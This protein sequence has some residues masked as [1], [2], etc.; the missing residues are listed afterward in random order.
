[1][2]CTL[3]SDSESALERKRGR[4]REKEIDREKTYSIASPSTTWKVGRTAPI[5]PKARP[6]SLGFMITA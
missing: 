6:K 3:T 2:S 5:H 1:M 4:K